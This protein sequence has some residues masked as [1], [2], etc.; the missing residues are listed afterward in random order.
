MWTII[1]NRAECF[2]T[3]NFVYASQAMEMDGWS[4]WYNGKR[5]W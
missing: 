3:N 5:V 1:S 4:V 2:E